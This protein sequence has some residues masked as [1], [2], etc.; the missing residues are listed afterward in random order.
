LR[1]RNLKTEQ[2]TE[3]HSCG[4]EQVYGTEKLNGKN[5]RT[6]K[7]A[8][9]ITQRTKALK[10]NTGYSSLRRNFLPKIPRTFTIFGLRRKESCGFF[11]NETIAKHVGIHLNANTQI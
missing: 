4:I 7:K 6:E 5:N 9:R 1:N 11:R 8:E 10:P 2:N 3:V